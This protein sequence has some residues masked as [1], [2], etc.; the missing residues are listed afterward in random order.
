MV[1][2]LEPDLNQVE[3]SNSTGK[4]TRNALLN[5]LINSF[6]KTNDG[7]LRP[8]VLTIS[9]VVK[10]LNLTT[11][12][13]HQEA[14]QL[15]FNRNSDLIKIVAKARKIYFIANTNNPVILQALKSKWSE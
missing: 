15:I 14:Y 6:E 8:K 11:K 9:E 12:S 13:A 2:I 5:I 10:Q 1:E 3:L 4:L 7:K